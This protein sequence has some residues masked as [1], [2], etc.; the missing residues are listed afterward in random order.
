MK[1][2][3]L[4]AFA[5]IPVAVLLFSSCNSWEK[6]LGVDLLP[7]GDN[8]FLFY[9]TILDIRAYPVTGKPMIT[10]ERSYLATTLYLLGNVSDTIV[11]SS[12]ASLITQFNTS[13][14]FRNGP[15]TEIDSVLLYLYVEDYIGVTDLDMDMT[16]SV[17]EMTERISM[18]SVYYSDYDPAGK[19][20][21]EL[22]GRKSVLP[23][24]NDTV[25]I[26][27]DNEAFKQKFRDVGADTALFQSDSAFKDYFNGLYLTAHS[28]DPGG[29]MARIGLSNIVTRLSV[30]YA[31]DSTDVDT[32]AGMDY[33]WTT[34]FI[35]EY[36]SQ[37]INIFNHSINPGSYLQSVI[38]RD[39]AT[40]E[41]CFV[42]GMAGVNTRLSFTDLEN[43][44]GEE[45]VAINS[46]T[47]VF[48][49]VPEEV[50]GIPAEELPGHL[51]LYTELDDG[52]LERLYDYLAV[53]KSDV[54]LFGG[55]LKPESEGMFHDTTYT[56]R[57]NIGLHF[58][59]MVDGRKPDFTFRLQLFDATKNPGYSILWG[60]PDTDHSH[61]RLEVVYLKL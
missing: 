9:D 3:D 44:I 58:Q 36:K 16:Y 40:P 29:I 41:Y 42:Q 47:L 24:E 55:L 52:S 28:D 59:A 31:N 33:I 38:D 1:K 49:A 4:W 11:G 37:K 27:L 21:P 34:F 60:N 61:I 8:V 26:L 6:E 25:V 19:F 20:S 56:Y 43:W 51:M 39:D 15:R 57:F 18:D 7:P 53:V 23:E 12:E 13:T 45:K 46:A 30:K 54:N 50:Y 2:K 5:I 48:E 14:V 10:S 35:N 32:T 22:L 17:Y